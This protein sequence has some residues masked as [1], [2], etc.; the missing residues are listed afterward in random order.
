MNSN[1]GNGNNILMFVVQ[2][3]IDKWYWQILMMKLYS[4][5]RSWRRFDRKH[6]RRFFRWKADNY[7]T[8]K[9]TLDGRQCQP[10]S[11]TYMIDRNKVYLHKQDLQSQIVVREAA[12]SH[13]GYLTT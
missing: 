1:S 8:R 3:Q 5:H 4:N 9:A 13:V 10:V 6:L 7:Q 12:K 11:I 2:S